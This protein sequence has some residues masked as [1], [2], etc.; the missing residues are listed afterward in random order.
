DLLAVLERGLADRVAALRPES[1]VEL[2]ELHEAAVNQ[3]NNEAILL[4]ARAALPYGDEY[5]GE[6][7]AVG[8]RDMAIRA[9]IERAAAGPPNGEVLLGLRQTGFLRA[10]AELQIRLGSAFEALRS[11]EAGGELVVGP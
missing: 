11:G 1:L 7:E 10:A 9:L 4:P 2:V 3:S 8:E 6:R 5:L